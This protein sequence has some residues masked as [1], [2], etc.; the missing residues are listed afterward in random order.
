MS[1]SRFRHRPTL[2]SAMAGPLIFKTGGRNGGALSIETGGSVFSLTLV[3]FL[4][5]LDPW[6]N[7]IR[8]YRSML[9]PNLFGLVLFQLIL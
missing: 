7:F 8:T 2:G 4:F 1:S 6:T 3:S 9:G 5:A